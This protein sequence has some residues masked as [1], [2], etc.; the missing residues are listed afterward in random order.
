MTPGATKLAL[1]KEGGCVGAP[2]VVRL[3]IFGCTDEE[4]KQIIKHVTQ[5]YFA[6]SSPFSPECPQLILFLEKYMQTLFHWEGVLPRSVS[7]S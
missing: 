5:R 2:E 6:Y 7:E 1:C 4:E 3:V